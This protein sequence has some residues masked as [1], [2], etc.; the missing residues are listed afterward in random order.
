MSWGSSQS[1]FECSEF[2]DNT[3]EDKEIEWTSKKVIETN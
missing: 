3:R 2:N 1:L